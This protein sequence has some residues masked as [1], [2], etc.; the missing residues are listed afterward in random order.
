MSARCRA[1]GQ[2]IKFVRIE[3]TGKPM[4]VDPWPDPDGNVYARQTSVPGGLLGHVAVKDEQ[5]PDGW[6]IY[7]PHFATCEARPQTA[8]ESAPAPDPEPTLFD[9]QPNEK[10]TTS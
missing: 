7:M 8:V 4:P 6:R 9:H 10:G 2:R 1:C 5:L 3:S